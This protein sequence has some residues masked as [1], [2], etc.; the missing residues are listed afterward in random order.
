MAI[1][2]LFVV[3]LLTRGWSGLEAHYADRGLLPRSALFEE[4]SHPWNWSLLFLSGRTEV[5]AGIFGVGAVAGVAMA[6][7]FYTRLATF[8]CWMILISIQSRNPMIIHGGDVLLRQLLFWAMFVPLGA[9]HSVDATR[10]APPQAPNR[11]WSIGTVALLAQVVILYEFA[12]LHKTGKEWWPLGTA[13]QQ[14]MQV[15]VFVWGLGLWLREHPLVM[16]YLTY[17]TLAVQS[18]GPIFLI[19]PIYPTLTRTIALVSLVGMHVGLGLSLDLGSFPW[20]D[21]AGMVPLIPAFYLDRMGGLF[22]AIDRGL[23]PIARALSALADAASWRPARTWLV[24]PWLSRV[25]V[26]GMLAYVLAWNAASIERWNIAFPQNY[27]WIAHL[28][29][30]DQV[31]NMFSPRP[32]RDDG[33]YVMH[34][35]LEDGT[36]V[37]VYHAT[38]GAPS[39]DKPADVPADYVDQRW[40]K[41]LMNLWGKNNSGHR[42]YYGRWLCRHWSDVHPD[43]ARLQRFQITYMK[44]QT[45]KD[46]TARDV[47]PSQIWDHICLTKQERQRRDAREAEASSPRG[48]RVEGVDA[49][50]AEPA[51]EPPAPDADPTPPAGQTAPEP[52]P[53]VAPG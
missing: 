48:A 44:E 51:S 4:F 26:V 18:V 36:E 32:M 40:R 9:R 12:F 25:T 6:V 49:T 37:D 47:E 17:L 33:W 39:K 46:G 31:W 10:E 21:A 20:I 14:A 38:V 41:Y 19:S 28:T 16:H 24:T 45:R 13:V 35:K 1:A 23:R 22:A 15:D 27:T 29:R 7:G 53:A 50:E 11:Y 52:S 3:D 5:I 2:T 30:T 42:V 43:L 34:G 8:V